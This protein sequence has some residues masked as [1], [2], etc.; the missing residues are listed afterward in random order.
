MFRLGSKR[1]F[2]QVDAKPPRSPRPEVAR[3]PLTG[4]KAALVDFFRARNLCVAHLLVGSGGTGRQP[5]KGAARNIAR[6]AFLMQVARRLWKAD[7]TFNPT[8]H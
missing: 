2:R 6:A 8:Q 3:V 7:E 4:F 1:L 5:L